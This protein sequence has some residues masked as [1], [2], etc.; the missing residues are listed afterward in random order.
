MIAAVGN[1]MSIMVIGTDRIGL[2]AA[3]PDLARFRSKIRL[4]GFCR[5]GTGGFRV[6]Y[7]AAGTCRILPENLNLYS[8]F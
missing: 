2:L 5:T 7:K 4:A 1:C 3:G 8:Y 6:K